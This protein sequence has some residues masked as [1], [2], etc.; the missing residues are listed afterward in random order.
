MPKSDRDRVNRKLVFRPSGSFVK[1]W[2]DLEDLPPDD[3]GGADPS[4]APVSPR[5]GG[6]TEGGK[7]AVAEEIC[8]SPRSGPVGAQ[9]PESRGSRRRESAP[10][11]P[12][13]R[14]TSSAAE[15]RISGSGAVATSGSLFS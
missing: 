11:L 15:P 3:D 10:S 6:P 7:A 12:E 14:S 1:T 4:T 9:G 13:E 2:P 8:P 5:D